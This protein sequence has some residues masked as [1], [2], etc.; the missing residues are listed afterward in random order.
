MLFESRAETEMR[1]RGAAA[2]GFSWYVTSSLKFHWLFV[3][4]LGYPSQTRYSHSPELSQYPCICV[5]VWADN[6]FAFYET[7]FVARAVKKNRNV[8]S[9]VFSLLPSN[10]HPEHAHLNSHCILQ[11]GT[12][13]QTHT[14]TLTHTV[15][16]AQHWWVTESQISTSLLTGVLIEDGRWDRLT[17]LLAQLGGAGEGGFVFHQVKELVL[18]SSEGTKKW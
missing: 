14:H 15:R 11:C 9:Q 16:Q 5:C 8:V 6:V 3:S 17:A 13:T 4:P 1:C 7:P 2:A 18:Y 12:H 10:K